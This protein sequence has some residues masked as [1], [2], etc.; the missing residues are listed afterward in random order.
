[1]AKR[2][3]KQYRTIATDDVQGEGSYVKIKMLSLKQVMDKAGIGGGQDEQA[4]A[5]AMLDV[6]DEMV[7]DWNWVDD[8]DNPLPLPADA[9][10]TIASLPFQEA[11]YLL[12]EAGLMDMF[13]T[14]K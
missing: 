14:K 8:D 5:D 13:D 12:T 1:M 7:V 10:G 2:K 6:L 3:H 9:P 4:A 11:N